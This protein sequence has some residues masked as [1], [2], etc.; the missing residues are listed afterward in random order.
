[1][2]QAHD[3]ERLTEQGRA[4]G[5]PTRY[6][7]FRFV[8]RAPD[9]VGVAELTAHFGL[10]HNAIRQHLAKLREAQLVSEEPVRPSG[11][12]RP[13]LGYRAIAG[14]AERWDGTSPYERLALMLI[15]VSK[16]ATPVE[17]GRA[18]GRQLVREAG[19]RTDAVVLLETVARRLGFEPHTEARPGG[20]DIVLGRCPFASAA[21]MSP[22][23]VC[24]LH[25][26]LAEG[27]TE[28]ARGRYT[29]EDLVI[30][31]P[32]RAGCRIEI[33]T[34]QSAASPSASP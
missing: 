12:G 7:I 29:V 5:S 11:P 23:I 15:E 27:I 25:R 10:N 20:I 1:M 4:L 26:A 28:K 14:A 13:R 8:E 21:E 9:A 33:A 6:A 17:V 16:G 30:R 24:E 31:S 34:P 22:D 18:A 32:K 3:D 19:R 2:G